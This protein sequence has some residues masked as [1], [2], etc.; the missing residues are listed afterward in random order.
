M[1][2]TEASGVS[3]LV[4]I[5]Q[6]AWEVSGDGTGDCDYYAGAN[7]GDDVDHIAIDMAPVRAPTEPGVGYHAI[8]MPEVR[9]HAAAAAAAPGSFVAR[10]GAMGRGIAVAVEEAIGPYEEPESD[11]EA[12]PQDER[13]AEQRSPGDHDTEAHAPED[14]GMMLAVDEGLGAAPVVGA[15]PPLEIDYPP[16]GFTL[17]GDIP[18]SVVEAA[19]R[20]FIPL[21]LHYWSLESHVTDE[22]VTKLLGLYHG[23]WG[24]QAGINPEHLRRGG[25][26]PQTA[27]TLQDYATS[28][29][30][31]LGITLLE[32]GQV[33][34][35]EGDENLRGSGTRPYSEY[36]YSPD[37]A[38]A[39]TLK[40]Q[41]RE[42]N[43]ADAPFHYDPAETLPAGYESAGTWFSPDERA[44]A[45]EARARGEA[46]LAQDMAKYLPGVAAA[47]VKVI[48]IGLS[49]FLDG[50]N[51][52]KNNA[53][54]IVAFLLSITNLHESVEHS[55]FGV[56]VG[57]LWNPPSVLKAAKIKN[58]DISMRPS[59]ATLSHAAQVESQLQQRVMTDPMAQLLTREL[60]FVRAKS[61][62]LGHCPFRVSGAGEVRWRSTTTCPTKISLARAQYV[63][64]VFYAAHSTADAP[65]MALQTGKK[66]L[67]C[68]FDGVCGSDRS[69]VSAV[70]VSSSDP[71]D[72]DHPTTR[73]SPRRRQP[74]P[75]SLTCLDL[76]LQ[77]L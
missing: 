9:A 70:S 53:T 24:K 68:P 63:G 66:E 61:L 57:G 16:D 28:V 39:A 37:L 34:H 77:L 29:T 55:P 15:S 5:A 23:G 51:P 41:N 32:P 7:G 60:L 54:D 48:A 43:A 1:A 4:D 21:M 56:I 31:P 6:Q 59:P 33:M 45:A 67:H 73:R 71:L 13:S 12:S 52:Q 50:L 2:Q 40:L 10:N 75:P 20:Q 25:S 42:F 36:W 74:T 62:G 47:Q 27:G 18:D 8:D 19:K 46:R 22:A 65:M 49:Q 44:A 14:D 26:L 11:S 58:E 76:T 17:L 64:L 38:V 3:A 72:H 35:P 30:R 69:L